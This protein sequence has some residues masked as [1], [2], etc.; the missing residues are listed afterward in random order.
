VRKKHNGTKSPKKQSVG[1]Y[2]RQC[3]TVIGVPN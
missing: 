2:F 1:A 3:G